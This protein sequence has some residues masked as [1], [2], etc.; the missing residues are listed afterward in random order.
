MFWKNTLTCFP[1]LNNNNNKSPQKNLLKYNKGKWHK[2]K[3]ST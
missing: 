3:F 2:K 1:A